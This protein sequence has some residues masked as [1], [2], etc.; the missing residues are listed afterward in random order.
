LDIMKYADLDVLQ[1]V[2]HIKEHHVHEERKDG[3]S[4]ARRTRERRWR[5]CS[6]IVA[7]ML[8]LAVGSSGCATVLAEH[9]IATHGSTLQGSGNTEGG[10]GSLGKLGSAL[11]AKDSKANAAGTLA[12]VGN[13]VMFGG[14]VPLAPEQGALGR[15]LAIVRVYD[16]LGQT[17]QSRLVDGL[18]AQGTTILMS[19]DTFPGGTPYTAIAAGQQDATITA[20]LESMNSSAIHYGLP[21]IYFTFEHEAN[22]PGTHSGLGTASE[23]IAAWDHIHQIAVNHHLLWNQGGRIHF[24]LILTHFFYN[25]GKAILWWPGTNEVDIVAADG[26]NTG[27]CRIAR[28]QHRPFTYGVTPPESPS[29]LFTGVV[30]FAAAHGGLPV[31]I[32][33]WGSVPYANPSVRVNWIQQMQS[34]VAANPAIH[35]TLYWNSSVQQCNY[36]LNN[37]ATSLS[38]LASMGHS[39]L[40]QGKPA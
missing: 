29:S 8:A 20:F 19:L 13:G 14:D 23:F 22:V 4:P 11:S 37:S 24:T 32:A 40:M 36:I 17:F 34:F 12:G 7:G 38:A 2:I 16:R 3:A 15:K 5:A 31:F 25:N 6:A 26:Y 35:A 1:Y 33:E 39:A 30:Q 18:L 21:A 9:K 10:T 27:G 28:K